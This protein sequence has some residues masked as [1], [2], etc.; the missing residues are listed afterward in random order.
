M[1]LTEVVCAIFQTHQ[2]SGTCAGLSTSN[3]TH[4]MDET[5]V[6]LN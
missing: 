3:R 2:S 1:S 4:Q 5:E 6:G